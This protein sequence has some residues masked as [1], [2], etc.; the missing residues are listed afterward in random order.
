MSQRKL[1]HKV[2]KYARKSTQVTQRLIQK[3]LKMQ[4]TPQEDIS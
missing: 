3:L 4:K 1:L 2:T